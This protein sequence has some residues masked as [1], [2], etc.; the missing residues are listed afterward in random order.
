VSTATGEVVDSGDALTD[1]IV[2]GP[3]TVLRQFALQR[4]RL[5]GQADPPGPVRRTSP[6]ESFDFQPPPNCPPR[7]FAIWRAVR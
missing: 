1:L 3:S 5:A 6:L 7:R 4:E 2:I